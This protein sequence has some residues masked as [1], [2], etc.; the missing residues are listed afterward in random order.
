M[1]C[2][3]KA[4]VKESWMIVAISFP[5]SMGSLLCR[6]DIFGAFIALELMQLKLFK[7]ELKSMTIVNKMSVPNENISY[8]YFP[9]SI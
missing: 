6:A 2:I 4:T 5:V 8:Y 9:I 7:S 1:H 3:L